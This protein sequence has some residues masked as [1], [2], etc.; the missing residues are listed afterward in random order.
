[1]FKY[2]STTNRHHKPINQVLTSNN[3]P[4]APKVA[5]FPVS[6]AVPSPSLVQTARS[7]SSQVASARITGSVSA[8]HRPRRDAPHRLGRL[9]LV[10]TDKQHSLQYQKVDGSRRM[11][12][13]R[14]QPPVK[15]W[16]KVLPVPLSVS[17][18]PD[19]CSCFAFRTPLHD[20]HIMLR[21]LHCPTRLLHL[22]SNKQRAYV[23]PSH[24]T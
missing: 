18:T 14:T 12:S 23:A 7:W 3:T 9:S 20:T 11:C 19:H 2:N 17:S 21:T 24:A 1:V 10:R 16:K 15:P 5:L 13:W 8:S 22:K 6:S 4:W